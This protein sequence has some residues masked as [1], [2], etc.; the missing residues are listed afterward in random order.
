MQNAN[1]S[2]FCWF[3]KCQ[4]N[5]SPKLLG[6]RKTLPWNT[7]KS[8]FC[9]K[10]HLMPLLCSIL[11]S[12]GFRSLVTGEGSLSAWYQYKI[13]QVLRVVWILSLPSN[14]SISS[15]KTKLSGDLYAS[16]NTYRM[17]RHRN[18]WYREWSNTLY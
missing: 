13:G 11:S 10:H 9:I 6:S 16:S 3:F 5:L 14:L 15:T 4:D 18:Q 2:I 1:Q 17:K 7:T 8:W 12:S